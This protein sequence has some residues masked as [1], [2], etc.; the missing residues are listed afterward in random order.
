MSSDLFLQLM[1][2]DIS[3]ALSYL[4]EMLGADRGCFPCQDAN[5]EK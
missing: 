3:Q 5:F 1:A 2:V 4:S